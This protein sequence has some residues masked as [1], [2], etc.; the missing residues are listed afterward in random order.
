MVDAI[1]DLDEAAIAISG[2]RESQS[3]RAQS[4]SDR[5]L[6]ET[7]TARQ[8]GRDRALPWAALVSSALG[9]SVFA[10]SPSADPFTVWVWPE[11]PNATPIGAGLTASYGTQQFRG[12]RKISPA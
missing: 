7:A 2:R 10:P 3:D 1:R 12:G 5:A 9:S 11:V 6:P 4:R 8:T